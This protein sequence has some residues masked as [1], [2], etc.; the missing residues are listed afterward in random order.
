MGLLDLL[1]GRRPLDPSALRERLFDAAAAGDRGVLQRLCSEHQAAICDAFAAWARVPPEV[2]TEPA[3]LQR[4]A[5]GLI[6]VA[7]TL[8]ALGVSGPLASLQGGDDPLAAWREA[9][10]RARALRAELRFAEAA[11]GLEEALI[12]HRDVRGTA[13]DELMAVSLGA[14]GELRMQQGRPEDA[15]EPTRRALALCEA[16]GDLEGVRA[17]LSNLYEV[18]RWLGRRV[19][20]ADC[21]ERLAGALAQ[22][23]APDGPWFEVQARIVRTGE[24][25]NRVVFD[26]PDGRRFEVEDAPPQATSLRCVFQRDRLRLLASEVWTG[27]GEELGGRERYE[28]ALEAFEEAR[29]ADPHDPHPHYQAGVTLLHLERPFEAVARY[30]AAEERAPGWFHVRANLWLAERLAAG[31]IDQ[32]T[33]LL[34]RRL[35]EGAAPEQ[36]LTDLPPAL[37]AHPDVARL[38]LLHGTAL[39]RL[40]RTADAIAALRRG[41]AVQDGDLD[42]RT[43]A[44]AELGT[45]T[46]DAGERRA[47]LEEAAAVAGNLVAAAMARFALRAGDG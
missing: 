30:Q 10:G 37:E 42:V 8:D 46:P 41:L 16:Q 43:R 13:V 35:E 9:L 38:H 36:V 40:E 14:L 28:E 25:P 23:G 5:N 18:H 17:Y 4:Y 27:R 47:V 32:E 33:F 7:A 21:A 11:S 31:A 15:E 3:A 12:D 6:A 19:E 44:L 26:L 34:L 20:A 1:F 29:R 2:R 24:P 22:A 45:L 39:R